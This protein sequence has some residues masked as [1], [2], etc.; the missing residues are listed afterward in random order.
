MHTNKTYFP[1]NLKMDNIRIAP[2]KKVLATVLPK[3]G[4]MF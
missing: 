3:I 4:Q 2:T 1:K